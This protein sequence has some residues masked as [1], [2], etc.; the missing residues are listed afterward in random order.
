MRRFCL[1]LVILNLF[2]Y[3]PYAQQR[4][5]GSITGKIID[6]GSLSP[7]EYANI[8]L[9]DSATRKMVSGV[10]SDSSGAFNL[11]KVAFGTY[12]IEYSFIGYE[13]QRSRMFSIDRKK[14][15]A[16]LGRLNLAPAAINM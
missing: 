10:V 12:Y 7:V 13:K 3:L 11:E 15:R 1:L 14:P 5:T 16:D 8:V 9:L 4:A 6:S 2:P